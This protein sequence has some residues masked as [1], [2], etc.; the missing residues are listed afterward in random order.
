VST[1]VGDRKIRIGVDLGGTKIAAIGLT[2]D[3]EEIAHLRR[4][5]PRDDYAG[6]LQEIAGMINELETAAGPASA[7]G[8]AMPGSMI[9]ATGRVQNANSTWLNHRPFEAD[10]AHLLDR[11]IRTAN[12]AN[13]FALS[14]A[15]DGAA[16]AAASVFGVI[17]G[18]GCGGG[19]VVGGKLVAGHRNIGGEWGHNPLPWPTPDELP[20]PTCWCGKNGCLE[21]WIS[22]P[23]LAADHERKTAQQLSAE[24]IAG[25]AAQGDGAARATLTR[26]AGRLARGLA[27]V[28]NVFDP[29]MIVI[30]GGLSELETLYGVLPDLIAPHIFAADRT[31]DIRRPRWGAIS[32]VR[33]AARLWD[34]D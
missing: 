10:L 16:R 17:L 27:T 1:P 19:L 30:G 2:S 34:D 32:G 9:P 31:V 13:C 18:T 7:I 25:R 4:P 23:A 8:I 22:G 26:H 6:T 28:V 20:G 11:P 5:T 29:E 33:G 3:D 15:Y 24:D 21:A 12:D 14:E